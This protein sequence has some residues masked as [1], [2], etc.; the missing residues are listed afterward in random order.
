MNP[1]TEFMESGVIELY[2]MGAAS[3]EE[4]IAVEAM[5]EAYPEVKQEIEQTRLAMEYYAQ[6]HAVK[7]RRTVKTLLLATVDYL[8]RMKKGE[9]PES[10]PILTPESK[11]SDYEKWLKKEDA[12]YNE[13]ADGLYAKIIGYTPK[14]TTAI[15]WV[16]DRSEEEVHHDEYERFLILEGTCTFTTGGEKHDLAPG[17]YFAIPLHTPHQVIVTSDTPCKAILQRLSID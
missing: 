14:Y 10:P 1:I 11:I 15:L 12:V 5:A 16:K 9:L 4:V 6:A 13:D 17:D 8:E 2:V 3:P 7:P